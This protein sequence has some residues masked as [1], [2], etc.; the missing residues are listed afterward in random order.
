MRFL[1]IGT[2]NVVLPFIVEHITNWVNKIQAEG[3]EISTAPKDQGEWEK[4]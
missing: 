1:S 3:E 2:G 4:Y